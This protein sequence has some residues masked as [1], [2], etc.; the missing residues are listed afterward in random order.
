M[1]FIALALIAFATLATQA[2]SPAY[3]NQYRWC[4]LFSGA[5]GGGENCGFVTLDQC[6]ATRAGMGGYC[7]P[8]PFYTGPESRAE[9]RKRP[10]RHT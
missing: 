4:V 3:A 5:Q 9:P 1:R 2:A 6:M 8:N 10:R 7:V